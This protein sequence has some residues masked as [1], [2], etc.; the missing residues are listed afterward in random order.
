MR[1]LPYMV[2]LWLPRLLALAFAFFLSLFALDVFQ[3]TSGFK[4]IVFALSMHLIPS[5]LVLLL[6][7]LAWKWQWTGAIGFTILGL[8]YIVISWGR[9]P[10]VTYFLISGPLFITGILFAISWYL[11]KG[12]P[13]FEK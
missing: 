7:A 5:L 8:L 2:F 13:E 4:N 3:E 11:Q 6:L 12:E 10:L 9:F 1:S